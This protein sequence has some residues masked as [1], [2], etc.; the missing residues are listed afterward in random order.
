[1]KRRTDSRLIG[2]PDLDAEALG[3]LRRSRV[4]LIGLGNLGGQAAIHFALLGV[5]LLLV[6]PG[7]VEP[8]N[9][10][11][12]CFPAAMLGEWKAIAR[13]RQLT[14][15]NPDCAVQTRIARIEELGL[16][17]LRDFDLA[18]SATDDRA[19]RARVSLL[20]HRFPLAWIDAAV[21]GSGR[22]RRG[23]VTA[24]DARRRD[25]PCY[26][27]PYGAREVDAIRRQ[28][29]GPGCPS[30]RRAPAPLS[31]P[32][33]QASAFGAVVAGLL[34][35]W[36]VAVL[37]GR[38]GDLAGRRLL[39][40]CDGDPRLRMVRLHANPRCLSDHR[41]QA[42]CEVAGEDT[43]GDLLARAGRDLGR[44]A[45]RLLFPERTLVKEIACTACGARRALVRI[46]EACSDGELRCDCG[47][48]MTAAV[49]GGELRRGEAE[50]IA[51]HT[52]SSLGAA[53]AELVGA[54]AG[55]REAF[56]VVHESRAF[57]ELS[58]RHGG[59]RAQ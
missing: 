51:D 52:W 19:S 7:R 26:L 8:E 32:T 1:M 30:W 35:Q 41:S 21:D 53:P 48:E 22:W 50:S 44:A 3:R 56:Y 13:A 28:G 36:A 4:A 29:R 18:V 40:E 14:A 34:V 47:A 37:T 54:A 59:A 55:E 10:G 49:L 20:A 25:S 38:G 15:L 45:E 5:E 23:T 9:L 2:S 6:D 17:S 33:L 16:A 46:A 39:V 42:P 12:Q 57:S 24:Y 27:C 43:V 31:A 11:N 58:P